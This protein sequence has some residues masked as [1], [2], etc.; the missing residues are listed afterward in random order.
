[1]RVFIVTIVLSMLLAGCSSCN[2]EKQTELKNESVSAENVAVPD[3]ENAENK[4]EEAVSESVKAEEKAENAEEAV[5][6]SAEVDKTKKTHVD[7]V[8]AS[9]EN[10]VRIDVHYPEFGSSAMDTVLEKKAKQYALEG[11]TRLEQMR[12]AG[13]DDMVPFYDYSMSYEVV[14]S[15]ADAADVVFTHSEYTGGAH[16]L[17]ALETIMLDRDG[18]EID[19]WSLFD[20]VESELPKISEAARKQLVEQLRDDYEDVESMIKKGTEPDRVNFSHMVRTDKGVRIY[21]DP[22]SVAPWSAGVLYIDY[23]L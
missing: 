18:N 2:P 19:P 10:G 4:G 3:E 8:I 23:D 1:M 17:S 11:R 15:Q 5:Q 13:P 22:Y 14:R 6:K 7:K 20:D 16:G 9:E 12:S 21:F